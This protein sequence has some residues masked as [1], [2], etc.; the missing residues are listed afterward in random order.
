MQNDY[1][2]TPLFQ[3]AQYGKKMMFKFL[4]DVVD[5]ECLNE[6]DRKVFFQRKDEATILRILSLLS[7]FAIKSC[8]SLPA[9]EAVRKEQARYESAV[10]L[11]KLLIQRDTSS[12]ATKARQNRSKPK[13]HTYS[14]STPSSDEKGR[15]NASIS[16]LSPGH[17]EKEGLTGR[18]QESSKSPFNESRGE[19]E[20]D[21]SPEND[22]TPIMRTGEIPLFLAT[23][24]GIQEI[25]KEIFAVHPQAFEHI[26][27]KGKNILHFA[28]KHR[29]I[30]I[31]NLVV[32]NEF[33]AR[34]LVRKLDDEGNSILHM[35]GKKRADYVPEKIQSPALQLQKELILFERVKEVSAD[36]FTKHLNE[37]KHTPE[38]LFA[39]TNTKLR[40]SA[41]DWLKRTS[42]NCTVVAVLIAT[43]AFAA[44]YTIPGGPN[45]NTGFPLLLYQPFFMIFTLSDSLTLTFALTSV[46]TFL[47]IL[48]SSFRFRDFKNSLI[49]KL[50][51]GFT[52]LI[53]SVSMMMVAF[54]ATI[55]LMIHNKERWTKIVL[56]SVAFL[57]VTVFVISYSPLY[58][59][60]LEACKYPLKLIVKACPRC[61]YVRLKPLITGIPELDEKI[62]IISLAATDSCTSN[63]YQAY[64][65]Q[66]LPNSTTH[67]QLVHFRKDPFIAGA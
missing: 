47:S 28:I 45:Q 65:R 11:A 26:N 57:P 34:N 21:G 51:L 8:W 19:G 3:A 23:W 24:S 49:Q 48:T 43:V 36:Y 9:L 37:Q 29:Q 1:G 58:L 40:K 59:S 5:K 17:E 4:A 22:M 15:R 14:P 16:L 6:E 56:Y 54:A 12:K 18:S 27:C 67:N 2:E 39:E 55:V 60:L 13:T 10:K 46:V 33:I 38:E 35:V 20:V 66:E 53:L 32:N 61:N 41:T 63:S 31:F 30:K 64:V 7:T 25:V 42:E 52:F 62:W 44:A 50:M